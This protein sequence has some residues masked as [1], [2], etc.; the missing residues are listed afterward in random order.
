MGLPMNGPYTYR[1]NKSERMVHRA[2]RI[3]IANVLFLTY[4]VAWIA[5]ELYF[6][7]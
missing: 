1:M 5:L 7:G 6:G 4:F 3:R 2:R